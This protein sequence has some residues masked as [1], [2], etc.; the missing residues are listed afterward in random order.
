MLSEFNGTF[1]YT[2]VHGN[3]ILFALEERDGVSFLHVRTR[4]HRKGTFPLLIKGVLGESKVKRED[5][6]HERP[7]TTTAKKY[8][9]TIDTK[10][11][12]TK[13]HRAGYEEAKKFSLNLII[14]AL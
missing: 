1:H 2:I 3:K 14:K 5:S 7:K 4:L 8:K 9:K 6:K 13:K 11:S 12:G 10:E